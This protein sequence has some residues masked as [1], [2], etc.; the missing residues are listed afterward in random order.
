MTVAVGGKLNTNTHALV[1]NVPH[2][3]YKTH[4]L[5]IMIVSLIQIKWLSGL[6]SYFIS[7]YIIKLDIGHNL[8]LQ[9]TLKK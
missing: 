3:H 8:S 5:V 6:V 7:M 9:I 2:C 4:M 1:K